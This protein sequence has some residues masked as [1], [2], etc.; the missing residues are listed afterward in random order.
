MHSSH[1][2]IT[3][4]AA[5]FAGVVAQSLARHARL[6]AIVLLLAT[7]VMLGP[8]GL[9]WIRPSSLGGAL[10]PTVELAVAVILFEGGL[11]LRLQQL[12]GA[13]SVIRRLLLGG[14]VITLAGGALAA[15][16][17]LH[18]DWDVAILFGALVVVTGP[19]VIGPLVAEL[20]LRPRVSAILSAEGVLIDPIGALLAALA[21]SIALAPGNHTVA[22]AAANV[23]A[24]VAWG[25]LLGLVGGGLLSAGLRVRGLIPAG[26]T[27]IFTLTLVLFVF[28]ASEVIARPSG[29]L[30][31][32]VMGMIGGNLQSRQLRELREFKD[33]LSL[34][35]IGLIF[36][37][38]AADV[39]L[40][41]VLALGWRGAAVVAALVLC[42]RPLVVAYASHRSDLDVRER[43]FL[44][45]IAPRG[46]VAAAIASVTA[47]EL[48][49]AGSG[50]AGELRALV[51]LTIVTTV[52]LAGVTGRPLASAL[53]LR[54]PRRDRLAIL[55]ATR[56]G[57]LMA[58][59]LQDSY[60]GVVLLDSNPDHIARAKRAGF[61]A[62]VGN[63]LE[64]ST[65]A[66][67]SLGSASTAIGVTPNEEVNGL[68]VVRAHEL[69]G[70]P[71]GF[72]ALRRLREGVTQEFVETP[73]ADVLFD[74]GHDVDLWEARLRRRSVILEHWEYRPATGPD[75]TTGPPETAVGV[76]T[77]SAV[78]IKTPPTETR[79][80]ERRP[81]PDS[82]PP[83]NEPYLI[84]VVKRGTTVQPMAVRFDLLE[85]DLVTIA[86]NIPNT[87]IARKLLIERGFVPIEAASPTATS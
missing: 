39:R 70:V 36:V 4:V 54:S 65:L 31:V 80:A 22:S 20:R 2:T 8:D 24:A 29:L 87:E 41:E 46:I 57:I 6:P 61:A 78:P 56:L 52:L 53:G 67:A 9:G 25:T 17:L 19:T 45:W 34:L 66:Q 40:V 60:G 32:V 51:F 30:A 21:L 10:L 14:A 63:A 49:R 81:V 85:G 82:H 83:E 69:F 1:G 23:I 86:I 76:S 11:N 79:Q 35:L 75:A 44:A 84:L 16:F 28:Q 33:Q 59:E 77:A 43:V 27:N 55:G 7:G 50:M 18:W 62:V 74:A 58:S 38:L 48:T 15:R 64:E 73:D 47:A 72:V 26:L 68:F 13:S 71:K 42:V 3:L 12:R 5:M 37:L